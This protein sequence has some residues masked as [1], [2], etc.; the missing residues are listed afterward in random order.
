M[1]TKTILLLALLTFGSILVP[2]ASAGV[3]DAINTVWPCN[4]VEARTRGFVIYTFVADV[5]IKGQY[6]CV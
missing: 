5:A 3:E 6:I 2:V 1:A 4:I